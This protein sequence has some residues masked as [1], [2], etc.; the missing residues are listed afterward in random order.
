MTGALPYHPEVL[1]IRAGNPSPWTGPTG[2]N[3]YLLPGKVRT[4]VDAGVGEP[5]HL[6]AL[7][8]A[9]QGQPLDAVLVTHGHRDHVEGLPAIRARW[10]GVQVRN[11]GGDR[12]RTGELIAA[13]DT[14]L[15]P[16]HTPG[17]APDHVCFVDDLAGDVYCGDLVRIGGTIV[18]Q[19]SNG[20]N[21]T[22]YLDSL[23]R[24]RALK[25]RRLLPGHGP[26]VDDPALLIDEYLAHRESREQQIVEALAGG[27]ATPAAIVER[28]Y[29][30]MP[31]AFARAAADSV[32][33]NLIKLAGEGRAVQLETSWQLR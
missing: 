8:D 6:A 18:I 3:T 17:H 32:L 2:N 4:L 19:A 11:H 5:S 29:G 7:E 21:L 28:V 9:L 25:P 16:L 22:D 31:V 13:G 23:R 20:G 10:P 27:C 26:I 15:R 24:L 30:P 33:A 14:R 1:L 12:C